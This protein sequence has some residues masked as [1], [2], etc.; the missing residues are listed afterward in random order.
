MPFTDS[1]LYMSSFLSKGSVLVYLLVLPVFAL[2]DAAATTVIPTCG[3]IG[4]YGSSHGEISLVPGQVVSINSCQRP[5]ALVI[6]IV[7]TK[8][9]KFF[10]CMRERVGKNR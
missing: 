1:E 8:A 10:L 7:I 4:K 5:P 2:S 6:L 3:P 9:L